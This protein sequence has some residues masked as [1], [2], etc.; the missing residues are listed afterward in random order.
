MNAKIAPIDLRSAVVPT[1]PGCGHPGPESS[2]TTGAPDA[3]SCPVGRRAR[4]AGA[5]SRPG[6]SLRSPAREVSAEFI[7]LWIEDETVCRV[8][9]R[10][11]SFAQ[12]AAL[13]NQMA[14]SGDIERSLGMCFPQGFR[15][16][17]E[18]CRTALGRTLRRLL[19]PGKD[20]TR[21]MDVYRCELMFRSLASKA[22]TGDPS[23]AEAAARVL[24]RKAVIDWLYA[25]RAEWPRAAGAAAPAKP[26]EKTTRLKSRTLPNS[27]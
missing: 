3:S 19:T 24:Q 5:R 22:L 14:S 11:W 6:F 4:A 8:V 20:D 13:L 26:R 17:P 21:R 2:T 1:Q 10:G 9:E 15:V 23:A 25:A 7:A 12:V 18:D 16:S 27:K